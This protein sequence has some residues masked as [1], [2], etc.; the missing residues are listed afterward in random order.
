[1]PPR[2]SKR[3]AAEVVENTLNG[4]PESEGERAADVVLAIRKGNRTRKI[5]EPKTK[6][7]TKTAAKVAK[8]I[9]VS[10]VTSTETTAIEPPPAATTKAA[11]KVT[12]K[13]PKAAPV[14][15]AKKAATAALEKKAAD[16][17]R[18]EE[19]KATKKGK[20]Q[21]EK[22]QEKEKE[23]E[24]LKDTEK[25]AMVEE[26]KREKSVEPLRKKSRVGT[27]GLAGPKIT[28]VPTQR[29]NIY[30]FGTGDNAELGLGPEVNAKVVK[31]PRL[32]AHLLPEKVGI[33]AVA[34]GGMH[35]LALSH[36][37]KVYSWGVNDQY[38]LGRE[39][40]YTPPMRD[41]GSDDDSDSDGEEPL[42]PLE[43]TPMLITA[44]PEGTVI[45]NIAAGDSISIAVTD[46]GKVYGWGTFRVWDQSFIWVY[47]FVD[48]LFSAPT[49]FLD[50]MR[51]PVYRAFQ[52]Y[53]LHLRTLFK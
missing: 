23:N 7:K 40:K 6:T 38:A 44:F 43:S 33:V 26:A 1:M 24:E 2:V 20:K 12:E 46:T 34:I 42:N 53:Y 19:V 39:T 13:A 29:L 17:E 48:L 31:R 52:S 15:K 22:Q 9:K 37:G 25:T 32:N 21:R 51:R 3:K 4:S 45:T 47:N 27:K 36:E 16:E 10:G 50:S 30:A 41:V 49:A 35:G 8:S 5:A 18:V 14:P 28:S 11:K